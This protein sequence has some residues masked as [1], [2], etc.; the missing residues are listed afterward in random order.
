MTTRD[1]LM[2][3][4]VQSN[5]AKLIGDLWNTVKDYPFNIFYK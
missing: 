2:E 3:R 1:L 5:A 4:R